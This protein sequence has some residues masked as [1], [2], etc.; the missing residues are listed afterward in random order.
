MHFPAG[1]LSLGFPGGPVVKN[2]PAKR[3]GFDPWVRKI[4]WRR[5]WQPTPVF[6]PGESHEQRSL[7]GYSPWGCKKVGHSW[8]C[9]LNT[10]GPSSP[11]PLER[12]LP[13]PEKFLW[14]FVL[15]NWKH[16]QGIRWQRIHMDG[17]LNK[18]N[19]NRGAARKQVVKE[20]C[21]RWVGRRK[22]K[23]GDVLWEGKWEVLPRC[24]KA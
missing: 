7:A 18:G 17:F 10:L 8:E 14:P 6:L 11:S 19:R 16:Y 21:V 9:T 5:K 2:S 23:E 3:H 1:N 13:L 15:K 4:P 20:W 12:V 22:G 24:R